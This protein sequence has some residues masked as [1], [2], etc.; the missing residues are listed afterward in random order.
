MK[1]LFGNVPMAFV[2]DTEVYDFK[3]PVSIALPK[4]K[5]LN[6]VV[7]TKNGEY[8]GLVDGRALT[9]KA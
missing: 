9:G 6:A 1:G 8:Y 4:I 2:S 7:V 3:V 5:K